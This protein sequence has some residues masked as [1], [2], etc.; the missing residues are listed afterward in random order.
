MKSSSVVLA[1][2]SSLLVFISGCAHLSSDSFFWRDGE[3]L[4]SNESA[5]ALNALANDSSATRKQRALAIFKL[6]AN[7]IH[8]GDSPMEVRTVLTDTSWLR[9]TKVHAVGAFSGY[10]AV[11]FAPGDTYFD[12]LL[13]PDEAG[14]SDWSIALVLTGHSGEGEMLKFLR[15]DATV[16]SDAKI[17]GF[18][19]SFEGGIPG[20]TQRSERFS[21]RGRNVYYY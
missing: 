13:Y 7:H 17:K 4:A 12:I 10:A 6:F 21:Q 2:I 16:R 19:L 15:G 8:P 14:Q 9:D 3:S 18:A 20:Y 1:S 5:A 11:D